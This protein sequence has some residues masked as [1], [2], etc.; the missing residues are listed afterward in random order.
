MNHKTIMENWRRFINEEEQKILTGEEFEAL[1]AEQQLQYGK[2]IGWKTR[3]DGEQVSV[4]SI[5]YKI[6]GKTHP[7][8]YTKEQFMSLKFPERY[9]IEKELFDA[10]NNGI[11]PSW[12]PW[13]Q[14]L[15]KTGVVNQ[16]NLIGSGGDII[17]KKW[18]E[19]ADMSYFNSFT[20][21][22][23]FIKPDWFT[24]FM[25][26]GM[27]K[28]S[29]LSVMGYPST[30]IIE[31]TWGK[32]GVIVKGDMVYAFGSDGRTDNFVK[33][34]S[35]ETRSKDNADVK[36]TGLPSVLITNKENH[37]FYPTSN[38]IMEAVIINWE[39]EGIIII[40]PEQI[41]NSEEKEIWKQLVSK[42]SKKFK[43]FDKNFKEIK[44]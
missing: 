44:F 20:Y 21:V 43:I 5:R 22:H 39:I 25:E 32:V 23:G 42:Y 2:S 38:M 40:A 24:N 37:S 41:E 12:L 30:G 19:N 6:Q 7:V 36:Y 34:N 18:K 17:K 29:E 3:I 11:T 35:R 4:E 33:G 26:G 9:G 15:E 16:K 13:L 10:V 31:Q 1:S 8:K 28:G 27:N 14:E